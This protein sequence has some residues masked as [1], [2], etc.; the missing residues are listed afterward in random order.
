MT[1][2]WGDSVLTDSDTDRARDMQEVQAGLMSKKEYRM[3]WYGE[4]EET[5]A[6]TLQEISTEASGSGGLELMFN[7]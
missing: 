4:D 3:K 2:K 6:A 5:A 1:I 7:S